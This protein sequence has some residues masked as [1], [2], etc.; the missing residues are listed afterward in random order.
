MSPKNLKR[1]IVGAV[2]FAAVI[3]WAGVSG[4]VSSVTNSDVIMDG[5]VH[6]GNALKEIFKNDVEVFNNQAV[7]A[8]GGY[9]DWHHHSGPVLVSV[10]SGTLTQYEADEC[11]AEVFPAGTGFLDPGD[12]RHIHKLVNEGTTNVEFSTV[13]FYPPGAPRRVDV[14]QPSTCNK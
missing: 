7:I 13:Y 5:D 8:P 1:L 2:A 10:K 9:V 11:V 4:I 12:S 3:A 6:A 14:A